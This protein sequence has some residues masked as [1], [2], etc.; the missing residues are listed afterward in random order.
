MPEIKKGG[1][2]LNLGFLQVQAEISED[3]RQCAWELYSEICT[4]VSLT[5]KQYDSDC[6]DFSGEVLSESLDS[7]YSFFR[8]TR[9]IMRKFPVGRLG[10]DKTKHLGVLINDLM[11]HVL[12]PFL[13]KW[14]ANYHHWWKQTELDEHLRLMTPFERQKRYPKYKSFLKDWRNMRLLMRELQAA[15]VKAYILVDVKESAKLL[16]KKQ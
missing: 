9:G 11:V 16:P 14:Q 5:G 8:E 13:E 10:Q 12:R 7:V 4:R 2:S 1:L 3:D 15:L 6:K